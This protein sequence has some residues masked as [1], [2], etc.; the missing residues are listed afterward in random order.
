M[1]G[2]EIKYIG[3]PPY[4]LNSNFNIAN[5][6]VGGFSKTA[7]VICSAF[8]SNFEKTFVTILMME[9]NFPSKTSEVCYK[10]Q[11]SL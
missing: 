9:S 10:L 2:T 11:N 1:T 8:G 3:N 6:V 4:N 7:T 5:D